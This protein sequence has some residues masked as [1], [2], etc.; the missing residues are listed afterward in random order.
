MGGCRLE[1]EA[2]PKLYAYYMPKFSHSKYCP[3]NT[4]AKSFHSFELWRCT[5]IGKPYRFVSNPIPNHWIP[6]TFRILIKSRSSRNWTFLKAIQFI[7]LTL[8][9]FAYKPRG[10]S[11]IYYRFCRGQTIVSWNWRLRNGHHVNEIK[12]MKAI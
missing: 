10:A 6:W 12:I 3:L 9:V 5:V 4:E 11:W 7:V 8:C 1:K 2:L